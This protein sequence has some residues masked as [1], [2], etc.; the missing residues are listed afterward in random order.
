MW[1]VDVQKFEQILKIN[2]NMYGF[3]VSRLPNEN[4]WKRMKVNE[5]WNGFSFH[6]P[7]EMK[8]NKRPKFCMFF[9]YLHV[10]AT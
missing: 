8:I 5:T 1:I 7:F 3:T 10:C 4:V 2:N 9:G 6:F